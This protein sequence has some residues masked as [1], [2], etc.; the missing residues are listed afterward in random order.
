[1]S[2]FRVIPRQETK[3]TRERMYEFVRQPVITE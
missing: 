1:M 3:L 2:R